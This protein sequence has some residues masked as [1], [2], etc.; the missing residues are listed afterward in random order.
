VLPTVTEWAPQ[1][2]HINDPDYLDKVE[3]EAI[4]HAKKKLEQDKDELKEKKEKRN[5][6]Y[7]DVVKSLED[8]H[9]KRLDHK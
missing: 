6:E 3:E 1:R 2:H 5:N 4:V 8:K 9:Q 7:K